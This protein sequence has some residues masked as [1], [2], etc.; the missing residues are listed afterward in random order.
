MR[1]AF[2]ET[3]QKD[4]AY[5]KEKLTLHEVLFFKEAL[6][7]KNA[8]EAALC[9]IISVF[10][11][12][13]VTAAILEKIPSVKAIMTRSTGFDHI[14]LAACHSEEALRRIL[15]TTLENIEDFTRGK[16]NNLVS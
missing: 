11:Y 3:T 13:T 10:I 7:E 6:S 8:K 14:D 15:D 4:E 16:K 2:F 9:E 5:L 12:S 1:I